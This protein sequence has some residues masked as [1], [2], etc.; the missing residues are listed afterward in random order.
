MTRSDT[1][2]TPLGDYK[3]QNAESIKVTKPVVACLSPLNCVT[4]RTP[5]S[6][7]KSLNAERIEI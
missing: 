6:D 7:H 1:A 5:L 4:A 2:R 3:S